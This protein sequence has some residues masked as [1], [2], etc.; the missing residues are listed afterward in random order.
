MNEIEK[1]FLAVISTRVVCEI[2][3]GI[4]GV[5]MITSKISNGYSL[6]KF[7]SMPYTVQHDHKKKSYMWICFSQCGFKKE[8]VNKQC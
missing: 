8:L 4:F 7:K 6:V 5:W 3:V 1:E 2:K